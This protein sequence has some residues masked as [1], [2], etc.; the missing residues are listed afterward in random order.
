MSAKI[1]DCIRTY[2][3]IFI[4]SVIFGISFDCFFA[5]NHISL[6][7]ITGVGQIINHFIPTIPIGVAVII[8]NVPL[9]LLGW[10]LLG[11]HVLI[12]SAIAMFLTSIMV[13]IVNA[14]HPFSPMEDPMLAC[15][16]GGV[17]LGTHC[18]AADLER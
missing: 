12:S 17:T 13:D 15:I 8:L 3:L 16:F 2:S 5:P 10:K 9:F 11:G 18:I 7:G 4:A 14:V 6:A 1:R